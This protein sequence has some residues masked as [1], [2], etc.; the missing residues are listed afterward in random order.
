MSFCEQVHGKTRFVHSVVF[1]SRYPSG[2]NVAENDSPTLRGTW[3]PWVNNGQ[4][5]FLLP[6]LFLLIS[7]YS[8]ED[9]VVFFRRVMTWADTGCM[10]REGKILLSPTPKALY[11]SEP[12]WRGEHKSHRPFKKHRLSE[13]APSVAA[14]GGKRLKHPFRVLSAAS[15]AHRWGPNPTGAPGGRGRAGAGGF[16]PL[17][18]RKSFL[19]NSVVSPHPPTLKLFLHP[20][21]APPPPDRSA[22]P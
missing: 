4:C 16:P 10:A 3:T 1:R 21:R 8:N 14:C 19:P 20:S 2:T 12:L 22:T 11:Y 6:T 9:V 18:D 15:V 5:V 17:L 7:L 13:T